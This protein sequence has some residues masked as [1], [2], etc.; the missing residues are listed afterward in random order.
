MKKLLFLSLLLTVWLTAGAQVQKVKEQRSGGIQII[1]GNE[2]HHA[3]S[4]R[5]IF[6]T[7]QKSQG[8]IK[9]YVNGHF[10]GNI[11]KYYSSAPSCGAVGCVTVTLSGKDNTWYGVADDGTRYTSG[12][13]T[14]QPGCNSVHLIKTTNNND[15][16]SGGSVGSHSKAVSEEN[17][18]NSGHYTDQDRQFAKDVGEKAG[19]ALGILLSSGEGWDSGCNR[20]DL[21][22][23]WGVDYGGLG[24]KIN[25]QAPVVF[26][27]TAGLGY[28]TFYHDHPGND[29]KFLW[30][31]GLQM[32]ATDNWNFELGV[33]PRYFKK[34]DETQI[35]V[36]ILTHYQ[37]QI[38][39][40]LGIIGGIGGSLSTKT[41][42]GYSKNETVCNFEW[43][44]G[45]V[46]R[47]FQD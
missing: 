29:K 28:N 25:Y 46:I 31:V 13:V 34:F 7:S 47:L 33:G 41:P 1:D 45:I 5:V 39:G 11:T 4:I 32:W 21:G 2:E 27:F 23:G 35:G 38:T 37:H 9:I 6:W 30:N 8:Y 20:I 14:L 40:C 36:S 22:I 19:T 16:R 12:H 43:N 10:V 18:E 15:S 26:G 3:S 42:E 17:R 44:I 24:M